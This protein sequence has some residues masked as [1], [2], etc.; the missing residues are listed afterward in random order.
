MGIPGLK[1]QYDVRAKVR[2]GEKKIAAN[3]NEY[4]AATDYFICDDPEFVALYPGKPKQLRVLLAFADAADSFSTGLEFWRGKQL[5]C[6]SKG[7]GVPPIAYRVAGMVKPSDALRGEPMGRGGERQPI[8]CGVRNCEF[9]KG[10]DCKPM[11]RLQFFLEGGRTDAVLQVD[12]KAWNSIEKIEATIGSAAAGGDLR[13]RVFLLSVHIEQRAQQRF[14]VLTLTEADMIVNTETDVAL[15][16]KLIELRGCVD[17]FRG[18]GDAPPDLT[19]ATDEA[20]GHALVR[21]LNLARPGW[22]SED[23]YMA[24]LKEVGRL[25]AAEGLLA[26]HGL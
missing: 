2:I 16:D 21:V 10:R 3:G 8:T 13:G 6:Y 5:T 4:P 9:F 20:L 25:A 18:L 7:A 19:M 24:R 1:P 26:R 14:P 17:A 11:G 15:A 12:T 22:R 23:A